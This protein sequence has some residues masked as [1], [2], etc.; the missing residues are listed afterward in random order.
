MTKGPS[1]NN[2]LAVHQLVL[3]SPRGFCA[4]VERAIEVVE[5]CLDLYP[6][7]VYVH[8][9]I[10]HNKHVVDRLRKAGA[11]FVDDVEEVPEGGVLIFSAHGIAPEVRRAAETK[12]LLAI[13]ATCPL[14][15]KVH[16]EAV[17]FARKGC[18]ILLVGHAGHQEVI[19][20]TG[21]APERIR[22]VET[23]EDVATVDVDDPDKVAVITQTT[24][25]LE[26][27]KDVI[28]AIQRRFPKVRFPP[29]EDICYATTNRQRAVKE[30]AKTV[31]LI[32]VIGSQN[33]SNS[34]RLAEVA[35]AHGTRSFLINDV[36]EIDPS[37]FEASPT[38]IGISAGASAPED[39][40]QE[41][42]AYFQARGIQT[43]SELSVIPET[44]RFGLPRELKQTLADRKTTKAMG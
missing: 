27:T 28:A 36:S 10:V 34:R 19:G 13:D 37:W 25:S 29:K 6:A 42:V 3:T 11:V 16:R 2:V 30:L 1:K 43:V 41:V 7:P 38:R 40:V 39:L 33:S 12:G 24:L 23:V 17:D 15:T 44:V 22:L 20:T 4:G 32:L 8:H 5:V 31:D 14:V 21:E 9:E 35:M 18:T 26:D